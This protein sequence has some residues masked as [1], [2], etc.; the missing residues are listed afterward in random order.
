[1]E[2]P[3]G[4]FDGEPVRCDAFVRQTPGEY[5]RPVR[6]QQAAGGGGRYAEDQRRGENH[7]ADLARGGTGGAQQGE[8]LAALGDREGEGGGDDED[9]DEAG[10]PAGGAEQ[11]VDG[12]QCLAVALRVGVGVAAVP[13]RQ[14]PYV[15]V[16]AHGGPYGGRVGGDDELVDG[17]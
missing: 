14:D 8:L 7:A 2:G 9:G 11:G 1:M 5:G 3:V 4:V 10:D 13:A 6:P 16:L 15:G 17:G 12:E